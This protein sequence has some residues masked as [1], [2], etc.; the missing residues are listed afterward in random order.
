MS[1]SPHT[2]SFEMIRSIMAANGPA[3]IH[4]FFAEARSGKERL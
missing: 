2:V 3:L 1:G 4:E